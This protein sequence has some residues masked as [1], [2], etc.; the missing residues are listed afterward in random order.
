VD[1]VQHL[2]RSRLDGARGRP[3]AR[4]GA[5]GRATRRRGRH[6]LAGRGRAAT[7]GGRGGCAAGE[8]ERHDLDHLRLDVRDHPLARGPPVSRLDGGEHRA[9]VGQRAIAARFA[10]RQPDQRAGLRLQVH[11]RP[12]QPQRARRRRHL[13]VEARVGG[14]ALGIGRRARQPLDVLRQSLQVGAGCPLGGEGRGGPGDRG[15]VVG[16]VAQVV[17]AQLGEALEQPR[18][19]RG[20]RRVHERP[21]VAPAARPDEPRA[22]E[23]DERLPQRDGGDA[24]LGGELGLA[25]QLVPVA[26]HAAPDGVGEPALDRGDPA[27]PVERREHRVARTRG[28]MAR[29]RLDRLHMAS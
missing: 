28:D 12:R 27:A 11:L 20:R 14:A 6:G 10:A 29:H 3:R 5:R 17:D 15:A 23:P 16:E 19:R 7:R 13:D 22:P 2:G 4:Y 24:E 21:A 25:R 8:V 1:E 26:E 18:L 9:V